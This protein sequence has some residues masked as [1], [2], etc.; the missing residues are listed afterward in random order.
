M[1]AECDGD[2][3]CQDIVDDLEADLSIRCDVFEN[4]YTDFIDTRTVFFEARIA[5]GAAWRDV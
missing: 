4:V 2:Q 5:A 1:T 3:T